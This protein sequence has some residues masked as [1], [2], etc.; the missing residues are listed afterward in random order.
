MADLG[1]Y[2][3]TFYNDLAH[4]R[5]TLDAYAKFRDEATAAGMRHFLEVF[6]PLFPVACNDVDFAD[7]Q[8]RLHCALSGGG[9][10]DGP[11]DVPEGGVQRAA[12]DRGDCVL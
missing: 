4:D 12:G 8:Q 5:M 7:L 3:I 11:A 9:V 10:A 1:L 6:N 2:A